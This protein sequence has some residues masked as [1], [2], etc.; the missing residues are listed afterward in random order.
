A[1]RRRKNLTFTVSQET[2]ATKETMRKYTPLLLTAV[3]ILAV[4]GCA[5]A[6][7]PSPSEPS[8]YQD[9]ASYDARVDA[10]AAREMISLNRSN[11]G[12]GR[13][14]PGTRSGGAEP[15]DGHGARRQ[16]QS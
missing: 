15:G 9:L 1:S 8:F 7:R 16:T 13:R 5:E 11:H 6:P 10:G 14:R 2:S 3:A 12:F 4:A